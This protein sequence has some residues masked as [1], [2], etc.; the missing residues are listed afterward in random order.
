LTSTTKKTPL[1]FRQRKRE[2]ESTEQKGK[3]AKKTKESGYPTAATE[4]GE[5]ALTAAE[6]DGEEEEEEEEDE[7]G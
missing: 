6:E 7:R 5:E 2:K 1:Y 4:T 3:G